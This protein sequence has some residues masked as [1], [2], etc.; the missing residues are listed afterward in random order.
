MYSKLCNNFPFCQ[1]ILL[2]SAPLF[3]S[4]PLSLVP[5]HNRGKRKI[6][7]LLYLR[8]R[9]IHDFIPDIITGDMR[10]TKFLNMLDMVKKGGKNYIILK[11]HKKC[12]WKYLYSPT[13]L[14][15]AP[16]HVKR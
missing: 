15:A 12:I 14:M 1:V 5:K 4:C 11:Y 2:N 16:V 9:I 10:Y 7:Y 8:D 3:I 6:Y 13:L